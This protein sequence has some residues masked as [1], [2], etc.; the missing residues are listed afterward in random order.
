MS[1]ANN[2]QINPNAVPPAATTAKDPKARTLKAPPEIWELVHETR[3][4]FKPRSALVG[5]LKRI[6]P[7]GLALFLLIIGGIAIFSFIKLRDESASSNA[8]PPAQAER[9]NIKTDVN[10]PS[11]LPRTTESSAQS[12]NNAP[13][14]TETA[15]STI[16]D[17]NN[18]V[19]VPQ[20]SDRPADRKIDEPKNSITAPAVSSERNVLAKPRVQSPTTAIG[21]RVATRTKDRSQTSNPA[22]V[23]TPTVARTEN[24]DAGKAST[25]PG[26]KTEKEKAANPTAG[27]KEPDKPASPQLIAPAKPSSPPKAKVIA[28]P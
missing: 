10:P 4:E 5:H 28:W 2:L 14:T 17:P 3:A 26:P 22:K 25:E 27:K 24:K 11:T 7:L 6:H 12:T 13:A 8:A 23:N 1:A 21:E 9:G 20:A 18:A 15:A 19:T 16:N